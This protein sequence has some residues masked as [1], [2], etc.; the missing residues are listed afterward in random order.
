[1]DA[2]HLDI[3]SEPPSSAPAPPPR[4]VPYLR[5]VPTVDSFEAVPIWRLC[6][7]CGEPVQCAGARGDE[8]PVWEHVDMGTG[9]RCTGSGTEWS[10]LP[11]VEAPRG[12]S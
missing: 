1:M 4:P 7:V 2:A 3:T 9:Q 10:R 12:G 6:S 8:R 5:M 11:E